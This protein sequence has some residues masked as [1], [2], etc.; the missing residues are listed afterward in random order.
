M[1]VT[2]IIPVRNRIKFIQRALNSVAEQTHRSTE[3]I[4]VDDASTDGTTD[5]IAELAKNTPNLKLV[6]LDK[7]VGAAEARNI[8]V[9]H[10][11][12]DLIAFLDS[13]DAWYP[14]KLEKQI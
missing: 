9:R 12:G 14:E 7:N 13:D 8:G 5:F 1:N 6:A 10:A 11:K 2:T 3:I 4:V